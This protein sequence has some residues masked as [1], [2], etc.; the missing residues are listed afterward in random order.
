MFEF[1]A[2]QGVLIFFVIFIIFIVIAYKL[3]KFLFK[4]FIIG[5]VAALFPVVGN[6][7]LGLDIQISLLNIVWFAVTG[8][9]IFLLYSV[10][11][12]GWKFLKLITSPI[13]WARRPIK[14]KKERK[15]GKE[16]K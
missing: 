13:R 10:I 2:D 12:M 7:F 14:G 6:L 4:A 11:K 8:I 5:L 1:L 16:T 3:V 15:K 9:G